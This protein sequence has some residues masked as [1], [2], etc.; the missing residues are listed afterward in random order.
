METSG[1]PARKA[2]DLVGETGT[3]GPSME[4]FY[5]LLADASKMINVKVNLFGA[6]SEIREP[7]RSRGTGFSR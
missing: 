4:Y 5:L 1:S 7:K 2:R 3:R 6:V